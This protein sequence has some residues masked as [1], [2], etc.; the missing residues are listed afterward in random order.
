MNIDDIINSTESGKPAARYGHSACQTKD[1]F[2]VY[3]GKLDS[4]NLSSEL[5]SY[6]ITSR[7]WVL[8]AKNSSVIPP[9]LT[10]H[11][12]TAVGDDIFLFGGSTSEGEF[13]S[14]MFRIQLS[15][16]EENWEEIYPRGGKELDVRVVAHSA[17]YHSFSHSIIVY[18]GVV[19]GVAR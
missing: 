14:R 5:W 18:G 4:G 3:G 6:N 7:L 12:L 16:S 9:A 13:S 17:V 19:A 11:T 1:G 8:R 2:A 15:S 10:R